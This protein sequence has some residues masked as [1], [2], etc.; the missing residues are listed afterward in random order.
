MANRYNTIIE[1]FAAGEVSPSL[2][3]RINLPVTTNGL[4]RLENF[5]TLSSGGVARRP[6]TK[7]ITETLNSSTASSRLYPFVFRHGVMGIIEFSDGVYRIID[8]P[9]FNI[10]E[11]SFTDPSSGTDVD[12]FDVKQTPWGNESFN[13]W[14]IL[15]DSHILPWNV[16]WYN[17]YAT[18]GGAAVVDDPDVGWSSSLSG[19]VEV[20]A[21]FAGGGS[22]STSSLQNY[23]V[24]QNFG[25]LDAGSYTIELTFSVSGDIDD[26]D[27]TGMNSYALEITEDDI[28]LHADLPTVVGGTALTNSADYPDNNTGTIIWETANT[29]ITA[30]GT[31]VLTHAVTIPDDITDGY[32][33][34]NL[35]WTCDD[36]GASSQ[37]N[38]DS[39]KLLADVDSVEHNWT[40]GGDPV[41]MQLG[42]GAYLLD[43]NEP[44]RRFQLDGT[45]FTF[46][47]FIA[48]DGPY[49]DKTH[50]EYGGLGSQIPITTSMSGSP[51]SYAV[52]DI[53]TITAA[54]AL[55]VSTDVGR[56]IR[57]R[58]ND[59]S[60][61]GNATI[62]GFTSTT[63]VTARVNSVILASTTSL[64]WRLGSWSVT[65]GFPR[66]MASYEQRNCFGGTKAQPQTIWGSY[67]GDVTNFAPDD[68]T[69]DENITDLTAYTFTLATPTQ[70]QIQWMMGRDSLLAATDRQ[71]H[72]IKA[73]E[74]DSVLSARNV[75]VKPLVRT[76][77]SRFTPI[78]AGDN[79]I[80]PQLYR[81]QIL[82]LYYNTNRGRHDVKDLTLLADHL[83][84]DKPII[85]GGY[86]ESP[87]GLAYFGRS[88]GGLLGLTFKEDEGVLAWH[89]HFLGGE[90]NSGDVVIESICQTPGANEDTIWMVVKRT[91]DGA[92]VRTIEA[93]SDYGD[94]TAALG[95]TVY[96]DAH[97]RA[98][99]TA[100]P[101]DSNTLKFVA[102]SHTALDSGFGTTDT[103]PL[104]NHL[105]GETVDVIL[106][107]VHVGT[108]TIVNGEPVL[109]PATLLDAGDDI[110]IGLNY[111][112][113]LET[114][115]LES[116]TN[117]G[118][119]PGYDTRLVETTIRLYNSLGGTIGYPG[120]VLQ[121]PLPYLIEDEI[122]TGDLSVK[123]PHGWER[124]TRMIIEQDEP[125]PLNISLLSFKL[126]TGSN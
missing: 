17:F 52:D 15:F 56:L 123:F 113:T 107:G 1:N 40:A 98:T 27:G 124:E 125:L 85:C 77:C 59:S 13:D 92:T 97:V 65:T 75:N 120:E 86:Q 70:E 25:A 29:T 64:E 46:S 30:A 89:K 20:V 18:G 24:Y 87:Y 9:G 57:I 43:Y 58:P 119:G 74:V 63:V 69:A 104:F 6:G 80:F 23:I 7:V 108:D 54:S 111:T 28:S 55:F 122:F 33:L 10:G 5:Y 121:D 16:G 101:A 22:A 21:D 50:P 126:L 61:W 102:T 109:Y 51:A 88:G 103:L 95:D 12:E 78:D 42:D 106:N 82:D 31:Q 32:I 99:V 118:R 14:N 19:S 60:V 35:Y 49:F 110:A 94:T 68:G 4:R 11:V 91:I 116:I 62:E 37:F 79:L 36:S 93:I 45:E 71:I 39:I 105:E 96:L 53:I 117:L 72:R 100:D 2:R 84:P 90:F 8:V 3:G 81:K 47:N 73:E 114:N 34:F 48:T 38:L 67:A 115:N 83:T 26:I 112:S 44:P 41:Y 76:A 66:A